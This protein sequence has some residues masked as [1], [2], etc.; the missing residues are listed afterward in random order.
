MQSWKN[1]LTTA[2]CGLLTVFVPLM[3]GLKIL[4]LPN[5]EQKILAGVFLVPL[6]G[7]Y[8]R[9]LNSSGH[10]LWLPINLAVGT[11]TAA[12]AYSWAKK[13][14]DALAQIT[15]YFEQNQQVVLLCL[16][17][18]GISNLLLN[19]TSRFSNGL[20]STLVTL[21]GQPAIAAERVSV[22]TQDKSIIAVHEAGHAVLLGL[23]KAL[24]ES[25]ELVMRTTAEDN[26]SLGHCTGVSW[27]HQISNKTFVEWNMLFCLAG[28]E[29]ER[30]MLSE[31]S[32]GG[33]SD[34]RN[35]QALADQY[36]GGHDSLV[37][38][39]EIK[40]PWHEE[41]NAKVMYDLKESQKAIVR[42][43]LLENE[44]VL[45]ILRDALI[46]RGGIKGKDF[47]DIL[48]LVVPT[49]NTPKSPLFKV[50]Q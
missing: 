9:W 11:L 3:F 13:N 48:S 7:L 38:F 24:P 23:H 29:A 17:A 31:V 1:T 19:L 26:G 49:A 5:L 25:S 14:P 44:E 34:Y 8:F 39:H 40:A 20:T 21:T 12:S 45:I 2:I 16:V 41:Y 33:S 36:I 50:L 46:E 43:M 35:W 32:L 15:L 22:T 47:L 4:E 10:Q 6:L 42:E 28:I 27:N 30:L 37:Y 18:L